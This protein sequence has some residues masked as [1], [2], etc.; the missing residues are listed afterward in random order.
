M[1]VPY[2]QM[3]ISTVQVVC[4]SSIAIHDTYSTCDLEVEPDGEKRN[5]RREKKVG[6]IHNLHC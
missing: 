3:I 2:I 4:G 5:G 1:I 6:V